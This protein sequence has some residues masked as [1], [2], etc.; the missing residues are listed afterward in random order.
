MSNR[1]VDTLSDPKADVR[2]LL[3]TGM[4]VYA[5]EPGLVAYGLDGDGALLD[6][7]LRMPEGGAAARWGDR[8]MVCCL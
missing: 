3:D 7:V 5:E 8:R 2:R 1:T 4:R 6:G